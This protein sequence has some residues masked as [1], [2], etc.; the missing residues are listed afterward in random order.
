MMGE[1]RRQ[2]AEPVRIERGEAAGGPT[3]QLAP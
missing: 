2:L 1:H 3:M